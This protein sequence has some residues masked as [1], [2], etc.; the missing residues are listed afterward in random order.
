MDIGIV[1]FILCEQ[2]MVVYY[3]V[4]IFDVIVFFLLVLMQMLVCDVVE[5]CL[6]CGVIFVL[7][8]GFVLYIKVIIDEMFILLIDLEVRVWWQEKLDVEGL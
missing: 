8:G 7:V 3:L 2:C 6:L 1:I 5:D 4:L